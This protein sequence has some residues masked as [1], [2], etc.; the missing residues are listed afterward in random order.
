M[1]LLI[2]AFEKLPQAR[3]GDDPDLVR[4]GTQDA[5]HEFLA[6]VQAKYT[7]GTLQRVLVAPDP[8]AR[9]AAALALGLVGTMRSN[10]LLAAAFKDP[11]AQVR[12]IAGDSI[13]EVWFRAGTEAQN[14]KLRHALQMPDPGQ[15]LGVLDSL[16]REAPEFAEAVNQRAVVRYRRGEYGKAITDCETV[17]RL[18]PFH[19]G[20]A[21]G[22][23][24][25]QLRLNRP[26]AALR[27]F[28]QALQISPY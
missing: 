22:M 15:V 10:S 4:A 20:A 24:Q 26:R 25:C 21:A 7:E 18:N 13:W 11:D 12:E 5:I 2:E 9:R 19:F 16:I 1:S 8:R 27:A 23:G 14:E 28:R 3:P 17:L 6:E